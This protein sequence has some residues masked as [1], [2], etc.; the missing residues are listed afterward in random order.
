MMASPTSVFRHPKIVV[1]IL[2]YENN[3]KMYKE[4]FHEFKIPSQVV[5]TQNANKFNMSKASNILR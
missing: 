1:V 4:L 2:G 3:Y 5:R